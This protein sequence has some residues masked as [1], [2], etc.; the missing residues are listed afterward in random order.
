MSTDSVGENGRNAHL[1]DFGTKH[2][3]VMIF[4]ATTFRTGTGPDKRALA[5]IGSGDGVASRVPD[6]LRVGGAFPCE[7]A[8]P[9]ITNQPSLQGVL[10]L[11]ESVMR[12]EDKTLHLIDPAEYLW[13]HDI[14]GSDDSER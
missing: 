7:S 11:D 4:F 2:T 1:R 10:G 8:V 6:T 9:F 14:A 12:A 5:L 13:T 3:V